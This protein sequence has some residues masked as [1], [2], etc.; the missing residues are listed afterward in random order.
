LR[1]T[2]LAVSLHAEVLNFSQVLEGMLEDDKV[3][4]HPIQAPTILF[5]C[6]DDGV[7]QIEP[8]FDMGNSIFPPVLF[9]FNRNIYTVCHRQQCRRI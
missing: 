6:H 5:A 3:M 9:G 1:R 7:G 4:E 2:A 8:L